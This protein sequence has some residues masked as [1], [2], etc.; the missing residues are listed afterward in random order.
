MKTTRTTIRLEDVDKAAI[1]AIRERY[2]LST[3]DDAIRFV[4]R[5]WLRQNT[6]EIR[7]I[8]SPNKEVA[9]LPSHRMEQAFM[10]SH[11]DILARNTKNGTKVKPLWLGSGNLR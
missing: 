9:F 2:G 10:L 8:P 11:G 7:P 4:L 5:E 1:R 3:N 6:P